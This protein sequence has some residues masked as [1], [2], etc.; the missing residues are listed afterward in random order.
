MGEAVHSAWDGFR[1][2]CALQFWVQM[3]SRERFE[4][5]E[6]GDVTEFS[7][8]IEDARGK[9]AGSTESHSESHS[10]TIPSSEV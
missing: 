3:K 4:C 5:I 9:V 6:I 8:D 10:C 7:D 1:T 2:K